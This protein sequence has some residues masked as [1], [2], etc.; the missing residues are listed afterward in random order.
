MGCYV[1]AIGGTGNKILESIV[2]AA[3]AD[4]FYT[5]APDGRQVPLGEMTLLSVD[6]DAACGNTTRAGRALEN[7]ERVRRAFEEAGQVRR[8]FHTRLNLRRWNMNLSRRA[9]SVS[10]MTENHARDRLLSRT[11]FSK[12][13]SS[14]E[15][16]EGFRGH[17]D[18]GVLFFSDLL[19]SLETLRQAG[20]PDEMNTLL[21]QIDEELDRGE[22]VKVLLCGSIFGGTGA[23]GIPALA[24]FLHQRY[25]QWLDLFELATMMMLPY[26]K[27]PPSSHDETLEIVVK[28]ADFPDKARTALQYYGMTG[29]IRSGEDDRDGVFDAMYLL[30]LPPES[31]VQTRIYSTGSQSQENDAH[32]LEWLATRCIAAFLRTPMRGEGAHNM[33]CYYYQWHTPEFCWQ[34]FDSDGE[35]YRIGYG[36]LL[37]A[38]ALFFS[39]CY[40]TLR[41]LIGGSGRGGSSV[42]YCA[43]Y[44]HGLHRMNAAQRDQLEKLLTALYQ[45]FAFYANWMVQLTRTIPPTMRPRQQEETLQAEAADAYRQLIQKKAQQQM[46]QDKAAGYDALLSDKALYQS[47]C[48]RL[49]PLIGG[50]SWLE[51]LIS[52]RHSAQEQL[53]HQDHLVAQ[54]EEALHRLTHQERHLTAPEEIARQEEK[55]S[56]LRLLRDEY[57]LRLHLTEEDMRTAVRADLPAHYPAPASQ[58]QGDVPPNALLNADLMNALSKLLTQYGTDPD[59]RDP[60]AVHRC[61]TL[62][63]KKLHQL[64]LSPVPD[65]RTTA[66]AIQALGGGSLRSQTPSGCIAAFTATLLAAVMEDRTL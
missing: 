14:L 31:F 38:A 42:G 22:R 33:D 58:R 9:T 44:F 12:T 43:P 47:E 49:L 65:K 66:Y 29:M 23:S 39:E 18:L 63:Q 59:D 3:A 46:S 32:M 6:V 21:D 53:S 60:D 2:Y 41:G 36:G 5:L 8:G 45:F 25:Q 64:I 4:A 56:T 37:K 11:L 34:S 27:V 16:S 40:P 24:Q 51:M 15:Y 48:D 62:L 52:A 30:G 26:Y 17:P 1:L 13:E 19:G 28:S 57:A 10:R 54:Q 35:R 20:Q 7:Y 50:E 55:L 61:A